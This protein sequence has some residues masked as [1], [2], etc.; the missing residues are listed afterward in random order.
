MGINATAVDLERLSGRR[1][2]AFLHATYSGGAVAGAL[3]AGA[4]LSAGLDYRFVYL[5]LL[6]PLAI[7]VLVLAVVRFPRPDASPRR[8]PDGVSRVAE[9]GGASGGRTA[10][11]WDLYRNAPLLL[12]AA[13][14]ALGLMSEGLMETWSG[15]YLRDSLGLGALVGGSGVAGF[16]GAMAA[17]RLATGWVVG[18][19][20]NR[21]ALIGG[22][23][24]A[25]FGMALALATT[26]PALAVGGFLVVGLAISGMAP[27]AQSVAGDLVPDR[28]GPR[29]RW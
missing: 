6:A 2:I 15:I 21:K 4:L 26:L 17:G 18:R 12:V 10:C 9:R 11:R 24:L 3:I 7:L 23:L 1:Y 20:G 29:Y 28:A 19:V 14:A 8:V 13:I 5:S 16:F 22:G 27:L 25:A